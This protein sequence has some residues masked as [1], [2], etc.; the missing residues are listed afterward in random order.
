MLVAGRTDNAIKNRWNSSIKRK[1]AKYLRAAHSA[2][3][4]AGTVTLDE[5]LHLLLAYC[6]GVESTPEDIFQ[7]VRCKTKTSA[8]VVQKVDPATVQL[9][10]GGEEAKAKLEAANGT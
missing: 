4:R 1:I 6:A 7:V 2:E 9:C 5:A 8:N 3:L 10:A